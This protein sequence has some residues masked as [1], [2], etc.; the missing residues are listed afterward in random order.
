M[1]LTEAERITQFNEGNASVFTS[2]YRKFQ[3]RIYFFTQKFIPDTAAAEDITAEAFIK[4]W[5]S[6]GRFASEKSI[7]SF[8]YITARNASID[9]LRRVKREEA[10]LQQFLFV[11]PDFHEDAHSMVRAEVVRLIQQEI[12][13]LPQKMKRV[14]TLAY[15]EEKSNEEIALLMGIRNQSVR[16]YKTKALQQLKHALPVNPFLMLISLAMWK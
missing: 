14:F 13:K 10:G 6:R 3:P 1:P 11:Q 7:A 9:W 15:F 2:L 12:D 8:L 5:N 16:N 4:L